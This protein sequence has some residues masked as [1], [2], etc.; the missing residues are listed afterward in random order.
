MRGVVFGMCALA[1]AG[2]FATMFLAIWSSRRA[3]D[4]EQNLHQ[5]VVSEFVWAAIPC[6]MLIAAAISAAI[7]IIASR[8]P[9]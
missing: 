4:E 8:A 6:L 9:N 7:A 1:A 5:S 3:S 2:V